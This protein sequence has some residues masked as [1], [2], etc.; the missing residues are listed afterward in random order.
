M[1]GCSMEGQTGEVASSIVNSVSGSGL[2]AEAIADILY[3]ADAYNKFCSYQGVV[4]LEKAGETMYEEIMNELRKITDQGL[5]LL[6]AVVV[7]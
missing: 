2:K 1:I 4:L 6:G 3:D 5:T 7:E